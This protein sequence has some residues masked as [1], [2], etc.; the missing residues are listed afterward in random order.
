MSEGKC[1]T[2]KHAVIDGDAYCGVYYSWWIDD[3]K[4]GGDVF[5]SD[6]CDE[7]EY[8]DPYEKEKAKEAWYERYFDKKERR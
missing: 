3:C 6:G 4:K 5:D 1:L 7:Y 8:N 2:C